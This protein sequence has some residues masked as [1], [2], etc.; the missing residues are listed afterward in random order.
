MRPNGSYWRWP[1]VNEGHA[2]T[3]S[4]GPRSIRASSSVFASLCRGWDWSGREPAEGYPLPTWL[5]R[6]VTRLNT[7]WRPGRTRWSGSRDLRDAAVWSQCWLPGPTP[8]QDVPAP[9]T[10]PPTASCARLLGLYAAGPS[11][12]RPRQKSAASSVPRSRAAGSAAGPER[13]MAQLPLRLERSGFAGRAAILGGA[14][15]MDVQQA[16]MGPTRLRRQQ[17][18]C[19]PSGTPSSEHAEG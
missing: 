15:E 14:M 13:L 4:A 8:K 18:G 10:R 12:T 6:Q 5:D 1:D 16:A 2:R 17:L 11:N 7:N 3:R 19:R 9:G